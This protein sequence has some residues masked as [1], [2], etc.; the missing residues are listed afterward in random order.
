[1]GLFTVGFMVGLWPYKAPSKTQP[2]LIEIRV[3]SSETKAMVPSFVPPAPLSPHRLRTACV[4]LEHP[5]CQ[6]DPM[7]WRL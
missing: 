2:I 3:M 1:L 7:K 6:E 4:E 5:V